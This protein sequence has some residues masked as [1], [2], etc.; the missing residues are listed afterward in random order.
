MFEDEDVESVD[1]DPGA[2]GRVHGD[3]GR[4]IDVEKFRA[5][6]AGARARGSMTSSKSP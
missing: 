3:D 2:A 5:S 1:S 6:L 4:S